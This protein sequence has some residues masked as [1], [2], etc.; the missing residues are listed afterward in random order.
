MAYLPPIFA[1]TRRWL[2][3]RLILNGIFQSLMIVGSMLLVRH[4][5]DVMLN[6][7]YDDPE[8]HLYDMSEV[9]QVAIFA[10]GLL[11]CTGF[12]AWLR[13]VARVDAE[14]LGQEY[15]H[16]VRKRLFD[17]MGHFAPR[18][19][20]RHSIGAA[21]LR[22]VGD[23]S[24][25]RRWV[26]LG[27]AR[28]VVAGILSVVA[29]SFMGYLD[30]FLALCSAIILAL[31]LLW[32]LAL[33]PKMHLTISSARRLRGRLAGYVNEKI[34]AF[35][36]IQA[37]DQQQ[38]ERKR[39]GRYSQQLRDAMVE[40]AKA[41]AQMRVVTDAATAAS[42]GLVLSLG[43]MQV[44]KG[45]TSAGNVVAAMA[46]VGFLSTALRDLGRVHEYRQS[47]LVSREKLA[48][49]LKTKPLK[50]RSR[51]LPDLKLVEG[52]IEYRNISLRGALRNVS[53]SIPAGCRLALSGPNGSGKS[54]LLHITARLVDPARGEILIDG[55]NIH[56]CNLSSVRRTIGIISPDLPL[57]RGSV[58]YNL[59]YRA[60]QA[61]AEEFA[62]VDKYCQLSDLLD[63][64]PGGAEYRLQ[65]G[66]KNLSLGQRHRLTIARALLGNPP[67]LIIDEIDA[68]LDREAAEVL[69]RVL[70][71]YPGTILMVTRNAERLAKAQLVWHFAQ[72]KLVK[73]EDRMNNAPLLQQV[74]IR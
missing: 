35:A 52:Q 16:R 72:G 51:S 74:S 54:T 66:G 33:G 12:A 4:A 58:R 14:R 38:R 55:Q 5:F 53:A 15:V 48:S 11:A 7:A 69:N 26:S 2:L 1:G 21:S 65:E 60:A 62:E 30:P 40:R 70:D 44:F 8:V 67:L 22:F 61:S 9:K 68:N 42:M 59:S 23:L 29:L 13:L 3:L 17:R 49:F 28:I 41:S 56:K 43:A 39:F 34:S 19:L 47:Y 63:K 57:M 64:L 20:S 10:A 73:V 27:L 24:A 6:P 50:G 25:V 37:F 32:N 36:V 45:E 46:V 31:G 18:S 71:H